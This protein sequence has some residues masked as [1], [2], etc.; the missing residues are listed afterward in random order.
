MPDSVPVR[1]VR[2]L[3]SASFTFHLA[4]DTFAFG[5]VLGA[6]FCAQDLPPLYDAML[7]AQKEGV[8]SVGFV[9]PPKFL[10]IRPKYT[11]FASVLTYRKYLFLA[12]IYMHI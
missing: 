11:L 5:S 2:G 6:T 8:D 7:G 12:D 1:K 4:V 10:A 3:P 9:P